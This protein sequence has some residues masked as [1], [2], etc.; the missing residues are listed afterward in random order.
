MKTSSSAT[1]EGS[2]GN[3]T[4]IDVDGNV[5]GIEFSPT[6]GGGATGHYIDLDVSGDIIEG[7]LTVGNACDIDIAGNIGVLFDVIAGYDG[8][9]ATT[10]TIDVGSVG[11]TAGTHGDWTLMGATEVQV[12][13]VF[14]ARSNAPV[15]TMEDTSSMTVTGQTADATWEMSDNSEFT[16][17]DTISDGI[18]NMS[19]SSRVVAVDIEG[20]EW[21]IEES[22]VVLADEINHGDWTIDSAGH[23]GDLALEVSTLLNPDYLVVDGCEIF[24]HEIGISTEDEDAFSW[25]TW[26]KNGATITTELGWTTGV[27]LGGGACPANLTETSAFIFQ[28]TGNVYQATVGGAIGLGSDLRGI[29]AAHLEFIVDGGTM[30]TATALAYVDGSGDTQTQLFQTEKV[31]YT[32]YDGASTYIDTISPD[33]RQSGPCIDNDNHTYCTGGENCNEHDVLF[34]DSVC[35]RRWGKLLIKDS[36][37]EYDAKLDNWFDNTPLG[38]YEGCGIVD[39]VYAIDIEVEDGASVYFGTT[40]NVYYTGS[41]DTNSSG[42]INGNQPIQL[43]TSVYG[44]FN[45]DADFDDDSMTDDYDVER[46]NSAYCTEA[47]DDVYDPL[48]DWNC[49]GMINCHD[50]DQLIS[51]WGSSGALVSAT[52]GLNNCP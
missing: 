9:P 4:T 41:V 51:N 20:G 26:M 14:F 1:K 21:N 31:T 12:D 40:K 22:A 25:D 34:T 5:N 37:S 30:Y 39:S 43:T 27:C 24:A 49:D 44:D 18:W 38:V 2:S 3:L 35:V 48:V 17:E 50:R 32:N 45:A 47:G 36:G 29:G 15:I 7:S 52:C 11:E 6:V 42:V 28:G 10:T 13:G 33:Y 19:D 8:S 23:D 16:G 46:F